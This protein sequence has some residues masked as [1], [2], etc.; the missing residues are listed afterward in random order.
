MLAWIKWVIKH[1]FFLWQTPWALQTA[2][3]ANTFVS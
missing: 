3:Q 1:L 2:A